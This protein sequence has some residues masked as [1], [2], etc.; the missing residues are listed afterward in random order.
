MH[1]TIEAQSLNHKT[2]REVPQSCLT[3]FPSISLEYLETKLI[4]KSTLLVHVSLKGILPFLFLSLLLHLFFSI[5]LS[6]FL[7]PQQWCFPQ[8]KFLIT[9]YLN[10][11]TLILYPA[12]HPNP[13]L[14]QP[15]CYLIT[16]A[17]PFRPTTRPLTHSTVS[18]VKFVSSLVK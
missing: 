13:C 17:P 4:Q 1:P 10:L 15:T 14:I 8:S 11:F 16:R 9:Y 2:T 18:N 6:L 3:L 5:W 12:Y 7:Q